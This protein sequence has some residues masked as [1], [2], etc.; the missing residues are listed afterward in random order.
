MR[1][2]TISNTFK[3]EGSTGRFW[4][5]PYHMMECRIASEIENS[6]VKRGERKPMIHVSHH[7]WGCGC[8]IG[9]GTEISYRPSEKER[10]AEYEKEMRDWK[11]FGYPKSSRRRRTFHEIGGKRL[12]RIELS[13]GS[14]ITL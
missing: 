1:Q 14:V 4:L 8:C 10:R 3:K 13:N 5:T 6:R 11:Y 2:N 12:S 9:F 7:A